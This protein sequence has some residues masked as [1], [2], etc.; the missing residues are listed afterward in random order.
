MSMLNEMSRSGSMH[1]T[2][3]THDLLRKAAPSI[4]A[5][6]PYEKM[7]ARYKFLATIDV[8][9][10][11]A[12][13]G[14]LPVRAQQSR[15]RID[16]KAAFT[17]HMIRFR[18]EDF[19][20]EQAKARLQVQG[21][22]HTFLSRENDIEWPE[23]V[24][25]NAHDGSGAYDFMAGLFRLACYNGLIVNSGELSGIKIRHTGK[26]DWHQQVVDATYEVMD[27]ASMALETATTWK[28]IPMRPAQQLA[29]AAAATEL[30]EAH[31]E[32]AALLKPRRQIDR[33][34]ADG[35]RNLW[36]TFNAIQENTL[37]GGVEAVNPE[38]KKRSTTREIKSVYSDVK[39]NKALWRLAEEMAK[40][41][42]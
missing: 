2:A 31:V 13:R 36:A 14:F 24:L 42:G 28:Q 23:L 5:T 26:A 4:F 29:F 15:C 22:R 35:T 1:T 9:D 33:P 6:T 12:E 19:I 40:I 21:G 32:P 18:H 16:G 25:G 11:L 37:K 39:T 30:R 8:V 38:T 20:G 10:A 3:M 17:R 41:A 27:T 7:S 34:E